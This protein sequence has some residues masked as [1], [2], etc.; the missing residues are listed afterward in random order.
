[1]K[2]RFNEY[3]LA[4]KEKYQ[5]WQELKWEVKR[6]REL[7]QFAESVKRLEFE[8]VSARMMKDLRL[9]E[10]AMTSLRR[11]IDEAY[12]VVNEKKSLENADAAQVWY[13]IA[14]ELKVDLE[15][16]RREWQ[17][18]ALQLE[19]IKSGKFPMD[20]HWEEYN[21]LVAEEKKIRRGLA[22]LKRKSASAAAE[23]RQAVARSIANRERVALG[24]DADN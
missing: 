11:K 16:R 3:E 24:L 4:V 6:Q 14:Q 15:S 1:M 20:E 8:Q 13:Q 7:L 22:Y 10:N 23:Y 19:M 2:A 18:L 17:Q 9:S 12:I 21:S 5:R